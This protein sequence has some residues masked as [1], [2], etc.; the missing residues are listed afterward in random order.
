MPSHPFLHAMFT[1]LL[2]DTYIYI[3]LCT[4][5][6]TSNLSRASSKS[7]YWRSIT[8]LSRTYSLHFN[9]T[10]INE[11][12]QDISNFKLPYCQTNIH[13]YPN[14]FII[15]LPLNCPVLLVIGSASS[16]GKPDP[17][18]LYRFY[19]FLQTRVDC[20]E[21]DKY[22][23]HFSFSLTVKYSFPKKGIDKH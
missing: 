6:W 9:T 20:A 14:T 10:S 15:I 1:F 18:E 22:P 11:H 23:L 4:T 8:I 13:M 12:P 21:I 16:Y 2:Y 7:Y 17:W 3:Y 19:S 5:M